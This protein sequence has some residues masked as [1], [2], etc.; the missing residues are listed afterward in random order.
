MKTVEERLAE[1][2][3]AFDGLMIH[4]MAT[5]AD[6]E[7]L[8]EMCSFNAENSGWK[9]EQIAALIELR[10]RKSIQKLEEILISIEDTNP[11]Y[12]AKLQAMID[13]R[14]KSGDQKSN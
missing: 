6:F 11:G 10:R 1:L 4:N 9:K 14:K 8:L 13:E 12:A 2:E 5:R 3:E 7:S